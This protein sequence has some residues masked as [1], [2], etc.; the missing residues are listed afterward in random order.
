[1][2]KTIITIAIGLAVGLGVYGVIHKATAQPTPVTKEKKAV[3]NVN[4]VKPENEEID[5]KIKVSGNVIA[6][7]ES[8][9]GAELTGLRIENIFV[10]VGQSVKKGQVIATLN[11][12]SVQADY[13]QASAGVKEAKAT[14]LSAKSDADKARKLEKT[15]ALSAQKMTEYYTTEA[16]TQAKYESA[17]ANL[18]IYKIK[19]EQTKIKAPENGI[20]SSRSVSLGTL[21]TQ[22]EMFKI[23]A[24]DK[25]QWKP[26]M[27]SNQL[28]DIKKGQS[29][30][31]KTSKGS[32]VKSN[33]TQ[34]SP[35]IDLTTKQG[36]AIV[37]IFE[38]ENKG[39]LI[40]GMF[41]EGTISTGKNP[42]MLIPS[43]SIILRDGFY[44]VFSVKDN[45]A[46]RQQVETGTVLGDKT[47]ITKGI[48]INDEI[49]ITGS[50]FLN[51]NDKVKVIK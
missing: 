21:S 4:V 42:A 25:V 28:L 38:K 50:N 24:T 47:E 39:S 22:T 43:S 2:K 8:V 23:I 46:I 31:I 18:D 40:P 51:N 49:V 33:I 48:D 30:E 35:S 26:T 14:Y 1:M 44:Y 12:K 6:W 20:V 45:I 13:N 34:I 3:L 11:D 32:F 29:V 7:Q 37:D 36:F 10:D 27:V 15:E 19:L 41:V 16:T 5:K 9:I 17:L